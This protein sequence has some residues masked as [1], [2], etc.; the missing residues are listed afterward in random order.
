[1]DM[2]EIAA[3]PQFRAGNATPPPRCADFVGAAESWLAWLLH[4]AGRRPSTCEKYRGH[5]ERFADWYA[6]PPSDARL[7]PAAPG[8]LQASPADLECFTG[9]YA[10]SLKIGPRA[11]RPIVSALR[12]FFAWY[13]ARAGQ[14]NPAAALAQP[15]FG[16]RLPVAMPL[17][18]AERLIMAPDPGTFRGLRDAAILGLLLG[19]GL[20]A[21]GL[22]ALNESDLYW[23]VDESGADRLTVR[24]LEK[25]ERER[26]IP[27][28]DEAAMLVRAY[29]GHDE[30][31]GI[32]RQLPDG[33]TVLF[34]TLRNRT[35]PPCDYHGE[36]RR[37]TRRSVLAIVKHYALQA[38]IDHRYAHP[39]ALR[40]LYGSEF[41]EDDA[42]ILQ[43][44]ALL[45]HSD[46]KSTAIYAHLAQRKLRKLVDQSNP[47]AKMRAPLLESVRAI[48]RAT[49]N[50]ARAPSGQPT[51]QK[52]KSGNHDPTRKPINPR[53]R[54]PSRKL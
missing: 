52:L 38:G 17:R 4:N 30:L 45:G 8:P 44:Q 35:I 41:A 46:A 14:T 51:I 6:A 54:A 29:L 49:T 34:V 13:A 19:G 3:V 32:P 7:V 43:A 53:D 22:C 24:T 23:H 10:H 5:L 20:R 47:M 39:H 2:P 15:K 18:D 42:P 12:G 9:L 31:A 48:H 37:M 11:R 25:G 50:A 36:A 1:M 40:H 26:L 33:E 21:S 16:R 27:V 28:A